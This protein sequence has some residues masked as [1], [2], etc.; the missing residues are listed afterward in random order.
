MR[1]IKI[2]ATIGP[3]TCTPHMVRAMAQA[4]MDVARLNGAHADL[5]WH[6]Q[7][8]ATL[9][10][11]APQAPILLDIPGRKI[12]MGRLKRHRAFARGDE[13]IFTTD[14]RSIDRCKIPLGSVLLH[15]DLSRGDTIL[16][17]DGQFRLTVTAVRGRDIRCRADTA[18]V[19]R[20]AKGL[21][22]PAVVLRDA[23]VTDSD[24]HLLEFAR[25][26]G[27]DFVGV[28]FVETAQHLQTV[29]QLIGV[30]GP[31]LIAKIERPQAVER[32]RAIAQVAD[33]LMIDRGDLAAET[34]PER[35]AMAQKRI[36][37]VARDA[38][39]PAI[40]ATEMLHSMIAHAH[41]TKAE[42]SDIS[43]AVLDGASALMLSAET[44]VGRFPVEAVATMRKVVDA[45]WEHLQG[46]ADRA[47]RVSPRG[48]PSAMGEAV[49][50]L[51]RR[52]PITKIVSITI[53]GYAA[54]LVASQRPRQPILAVSNDVAN[55]RTFNLLPGTHG[56]YLNIPFSRTSTD[57]IA[58]CLERLWQA[59]HL[60]DEDLILVTALSYPKS[61]NRFNAVQTHR[62][63]DLRESLQWT[64]RRSIRAGGRVH[65]CVR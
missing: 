23:I 59:G 5:A 39:C 22:A 20:S 26:E 18:G 2:V 46:E 34:V 60:T 24:R 38:N 29:R 48:I 61:G 4:G 58:A 11:V 41:P 62:V 10:S 28:S 17:D 16:G 13:L 64:R 52:L 25:A 51:C 33:A 56:I 43:N 40:V 7:A 50:L 8:V 12:R 63:A 36:L 3:K 31:R 57:H 19:L 49:A 54:R 44:A 42:I 27:L 6:R 21:N 1:Q 14:A 15:Q 32:L 53:S 47:M 55:A 9:R 37:A 35:I 65:A 45:V 30:R